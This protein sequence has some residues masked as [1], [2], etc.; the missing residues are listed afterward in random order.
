VFSCSASGLFLFLFRS[1][2]LFV[3]SRF[4][5]FA[6]WSLY[7]V[8]FVHLVY[9]GLYGNYIGP[10]IDDVEEVEEE[11]M[12][13]RARD[14]PLFI[15]TSFGENTTMMLKRFESRESFSSDFRTKVFHSG[16]LCTTNT[17]KSKRIR[18]SKRNKIPKCFRH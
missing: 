12:N 11:W 6:L 14:D 5:T 9:Y 4:I 7:L 2:V 1:F 3:R 10:E 8:F 18:R 15:L 16:E 13:Q 17:R